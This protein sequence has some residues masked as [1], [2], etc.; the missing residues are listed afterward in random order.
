[1][2]P[3]VVSAPKLSQLIR[4]PCSCIRTAA[5]SADARELQFYKNGSCF[6]AVTLYSCI[7]KAAVSSALFLQCL[8]SAA[9]LAS[10][11][12]AVSTRTAA[13][14]A[15]VSAAAVTTTAPPP[16]GSVR[17]QLFQLSLPVGEFP[18]TTNPPPGNVIFSQR[19]AVSGSRSGLQYTSHCFSDPPHLYLPPPPSSPPP[20]VLS[21]RQISV[22]LFNWIFSSR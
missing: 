13:V 7:T 9:V 18:P 5:V 12:T 11:T 4:A 3:S 22:R 15:A 8:L 1:M 17:L 10:R 2:R 21:R 19:A 16:F 14:S 20:S 6:S